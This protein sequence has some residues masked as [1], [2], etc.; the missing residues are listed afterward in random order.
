MKERK[1]VLM[2]LQLTKNEML[3]YR[4]IKVLKLLHIL[5]IKK[6]DSHNYRILAEKQQLNEREIPQKDM[7]ILDKNKI[8]GIGKSKT[9]NKIALMIVDHLAWKMN[10]NI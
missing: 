2:Q 3:L 10:F 8:D 6:K 4:N 1:F 7:S 5:Q 9:E